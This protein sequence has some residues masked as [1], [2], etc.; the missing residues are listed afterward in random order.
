MPSPGSS[1][2]T[3]AST[4]DAP[5]RH[6]LRARPFQL[7]FAG[8]SL[9]L[10]GDAVVPVAL[11]LA[12]LDG[13]GGAGA[14]ALLLGC[15]MVPR[16]LLLP[17]GGVVGDRIDARTV[18]V[19]TALVRA[20]AQL[21]VGVR[22]LAGSPALWQLAV[23]EAVGGVA[24]AFA[25]PA[26]SPLV[27]GAVPEGPGRQ[28]A[29][30]ALSAAAS[31]ARLAG[32]ALAGVLLLAGPGWAFLAVG[33][34]YV[35]SAALL[36]PVRVA[37]LPAPRRSLGADL[38]E[39]W[40]EVRSRDWYWTSLV[41]HSVWNGAAAVMAT[42]GPVL[43]LSE[44][45]GE[46]AW[47]ALSTAAGVGLLLGSLAA[48]RVRPRNPVLTGNLA[49][50][51]YALPLALLALS[52]PLWLLIG[53]YGLALAGLG[54]L[55]PLWETAVQQHIPGPVLARVVS[56]DSLLSLAAMPVGYVLAPLAAAAWGPQVPLLAAA[57][58]VAAACAGTA[59]APGVRAFGRPAR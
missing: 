13:I 43:A 17:L 52:A 34:G 6:P 19:A 27:T 16:L 5:P 51:S 57:G 30:A 54:L 48:D 45:G 31:A 56:Y 20:A 4:L 46:G 37:H 58:L 3:A 44:L 7:L 26:L 49:L 38:R 29:N 55:N 41:A 10:L 32:P 59:A 36:A 9:A 21:F 25:H 50:A 8:R 40:S 18:A 14:I 28:R 35:L 15:A 53:A 2:A 47:I 1:P 42:L 22:L 23:A 24:M 12:V 11:A 33:A 39:G